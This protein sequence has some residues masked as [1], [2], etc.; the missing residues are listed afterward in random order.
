MSVGI[1]W[2]EAF[3][4]LGESSLDTAWRLCR[5]SFRRAGADG[6]ILSFFFILLPKIVTLR[7]IQFNNYKTCGLFVLI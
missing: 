3:P 7:L 6:I 2:P 5:A 4:L 1:Y